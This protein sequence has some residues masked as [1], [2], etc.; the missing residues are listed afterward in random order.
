MHTLILPHIIFRYIYV[1]KISPRKLNK[2]GE[3]IRR[4]ITVHG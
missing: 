4:G 2:Y 3:S 1:A